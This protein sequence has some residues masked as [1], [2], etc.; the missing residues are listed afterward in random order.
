KRLRNGKD[1]VFI[2][3]GDPA[4][5]S[6]WSYL[7]QEIL[8]SEIGAEIEVEMVPGITSMSAAAAETLTPLIDGDERLAIVPATYGVSDIEAIFKENTKNNA[9]VLNVLVDTLVLMKIGKNF[10]SVLQLL[11]EYNLLQHS[12]LVSS[13]TTKTQRIYRGAE[14][15]DLP[16]NNIPYFSI[17]LIFLKNAKKRE[18]MQS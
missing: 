5:Y 2:T 16:S 6:T 7:Y 14:M 8:N 4:I 13:A 9:N 1:V 15:L 12:I 17:M 10:S 18:G 11:R 3:E